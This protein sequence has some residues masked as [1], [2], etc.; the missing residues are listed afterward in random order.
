MTKWYVGT[1]EER[2]G[3]LEWKCTIRFYMMDSGL[4]DDYLDNVAKNWRLE[5]AEWAE[6]YR[7][8]DHGDGIAVIAGKWKEVSFHVYESLVGI[9]TEL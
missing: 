4:P 8:Y 5:D 6:D 7:G 9:V 2:C 1:I 3:E